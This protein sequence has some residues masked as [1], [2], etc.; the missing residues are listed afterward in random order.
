M[1]LIPQQDVVVVTARDVFGAGSLQEL[2]AET[3]KGKLE[4]YPPCRIVSIIGD[5]VVAGVY[6]L[7]AVVETI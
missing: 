7:T 6:V 5:K 3:L 2:A 4:T 1:P